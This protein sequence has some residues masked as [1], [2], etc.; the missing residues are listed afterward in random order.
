[1]THWFNRRPGQDVVSTSDQNQ[2]P[3]D[4]RLD[5][6]MMLVGATH[7]DWARVPPETPHSDAGKQ[8]R[9]KSRFVAP[10]PKCQ[11]ECLHHTFEGSEL[12][13]AECTDGCAF[14]WYKLPEK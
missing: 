3:H 2:P 1:M 8:L 4:E 5:E 7:F 12:Q 10:C 14:I 11:R 6:H 9:A 13:V